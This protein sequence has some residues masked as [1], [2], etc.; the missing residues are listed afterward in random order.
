MGER[1]Q[2]EQDLEAGEQRQLAVAL[3]VEK[4]LSVAEVGMAHGPRN[5]EDFQQC[6]ACVM[7]NAQR[8]LSTD[9]QALTSN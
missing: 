2:S 8:P 6:H 3:L 5:G 4:V 7:P 1:N 9:N